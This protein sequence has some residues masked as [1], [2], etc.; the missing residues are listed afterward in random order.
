MNSIMS[1]ALMSNNCVRRMI[2]DGLLQSNGKRIET[3]VLT[4]YK[5][6]TVE[7]V[8]RKGLDQKRNHGSG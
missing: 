6:E 5:N 8:L 2:A 1:L 7:A 3:V 4:R